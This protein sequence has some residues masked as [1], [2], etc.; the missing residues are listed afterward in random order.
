MQI[1][2][3]SNEL[4][5]N[6]AFKLFKAFIAEYLIYFMNIPCALKNFNSFRKEKTKDAL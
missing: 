1:H 2:I 4:F 6:I 5:I 3:Y